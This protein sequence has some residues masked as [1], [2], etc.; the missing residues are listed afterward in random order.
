MSQGLQGQS[1][2]QHARQDAPGLLYNYTTKGNMLLAHRQEYVAMGLYHIAKA[3]SF[4]N[5][6][7]KLVRTTSDSFQSQA[8]P[9]SFTLDQP[10]T[11]LISNV[12]MLASLGKFGMM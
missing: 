2:A 8:S 1:H 4:I 12:Q 7:C 6:D 9:S 10:L 3:V 11:N 5:S